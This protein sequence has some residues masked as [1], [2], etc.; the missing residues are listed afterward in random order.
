[1]NKKGIQVEFATPEKRD[2]KKIKLDKK[3]LVDNFDEVVDL[4][5]EVFGGYLNI[6]FC[7]NNGRVIIA[8]KNEHAETNSI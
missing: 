8:R 2:I 1:M 3:N 7:K 5:A 6:A 4:S